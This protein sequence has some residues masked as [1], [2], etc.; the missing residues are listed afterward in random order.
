MFNVMEHLWKTS[1][2]MFI[3]VIAA[4]NSRSLK[5]NAACYKEA[6]KYSRFSHE[7]FPAEE[8]QHDGQVQPN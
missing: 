1:V 7:D 3:D 4:I 5:K 2:P 8:N 6:A